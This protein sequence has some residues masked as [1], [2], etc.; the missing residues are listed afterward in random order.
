MSVCGCA[1][2]ARTTRSNEDGCV[3]AL[4]VYS[5][6]AVLLCPAAVSNADR[7]GNEHLIAPGSGTLRLLAGLHA[8][9]C[10]SVFFFFF[11]PELFTAVFG[12][13]PS[14]TRTS[15]DFPNT[16]VE[17]LHVC[18]CTRRQKHAQGCACPCSLHAMRHVWLSFVC[19]AVFHKMAFQSTLKSRK[20]EEKS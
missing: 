14:G 20:M 7:C 2:W 15:T 13:T 3:P 16:F 8:C 9:I 19:T 18:E 12:S 4:R 5:E 1:A 17:Y 6:P 11:L 10:I